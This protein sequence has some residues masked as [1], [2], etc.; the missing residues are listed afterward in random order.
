VVTPASAPPLPPASSSPTSRAP[1]LWYR[2][3]LGFKNGGARGDADEAFGIA[4]VGRRPGFHF[5]SAGG[6]MPAR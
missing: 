6:R 4:D 2:T 5:K 1:S 3:V